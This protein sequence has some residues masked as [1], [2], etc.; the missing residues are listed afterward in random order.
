MKHSSEIIRKAERYIQ[1]N[2][3]TEAIN[4]LSQAHKTNSND[5]ALLFLIGSCHMMERQPKKAIH[6]LERAKLFTPD[7]INIHL[8]L[9]SAYA[10]TNNLEK[11][12]EYWGSALVIDPRS[13][14]ALINRANAYIELEE[15][16]N[17]A[18]DFERAAISCR[19]ALFDY[20]KIVTSCLKRQKYSEALKY[21]DRILLI[22]DDFTSA[23]A[24]RGDA[25]CHLYMLTEASHAYKTAIRYNPDIIELYFNLAHAFRM[26]HQYNEALLVYDRAILKWPN[27]PYLYIEKAHTLKGMGHTKDSLACFNKAIDI[28]ANNIDA[29]DGRASCFYEAGFLDLALKDY[30]HAA[31]TQNDPY[32]RLELRG[33]IRRK[34]CDWSEL[35]SEIAAYNP[36]YR[37]NSP[38]T[39]A[40]PILSISH[41]ESINTA[42]AKSFTELQLIGQKFPLVSDFA[43]EK[44]KI[45]IAIISSDFYD[46]AST[47][48]IIGVIESIN[49]D[50]FN[51]TG[52][53][54]G[55]PKHDNYH[56]RI[57][58][59]FDD[60]FDLK[61]L[62]DAN[63]ANFIRDKNVHIAIDLKGH[64]NGGRIGIFA[65]RAA[66]IQINYLG[67]P[68]STG[69]DFMDFIIADPIVIPP[70][71]EKFFV[72][73]I[74]RLPNCYQ[75]NDAN[76]V[77]SNNIYSREEIGI[78]SKDFV[79]CCFNNSFKILPDI[80]E[81][82]INIL[83]KTP[84]SVLWLIEDNHWATTN[85][86][87]AV[88]K[89][90][91]DSSRLIFSPR[92]TIHEH[93]ARHRLADLFLDTLPYNA[94]TTASDA[95]YMG[96]P[97]ITCI[98]KTF[99][100]RVCASLLCAAGLSE[101]ITRNLDEY[102]SLAI[103]LALNPSKLDIFKQRLVSASHQ[104]QLFN[105]KQYTRNLENALIEAYKQ[106]R[107]NKS[108]TNIYVCQP[109]Q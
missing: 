64:T 35:N 9:G 34:M 94:H 23:H 8:A 85:L 97:V 59:A 41:N 20:I 70:R 43:V 46:H 53:S 82:W 106:H 80:F 75:P 56:T 92:I 51:V 61:D 4:I 28:D 12:I 67:Y 16:Q 42:V 6:F 49:R 15:F 3:I 68:G 38:V 1:S 13:Y 54:I 103:A 57:S 105:T 14:D 5:P 77:V 102:Q 2:N 63:I 87:N 39:S 72:E 100:S 10:A 58:N 36:N 45:S 47:H 17:A 26:N 48:L 19:D 37:H 32:Y 22:Q 79:Y 71:N 108:F 93:L 88:E 44:D 65:H 11:A 104:T 83:N 18:E 76:K 62:S 86:K 78:P 24:L 91:I 89:K 66:P 7:F 29:L 90:G 55:F 73:K 31:D 30:N 96:V 81:A 50:L 107:S 101:L 25:L 98:G 69:A 95:L 99:A 84:Q 60:F 40:F 33:F 109:H 52:I 74:I 21:A 27:D